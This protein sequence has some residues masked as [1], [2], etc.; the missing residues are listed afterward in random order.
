M[1][2]FDRRKMAYEAALRLYKDTQAAAPITSGSRTSAVDSHV[3]EFHLD[4]SPCRRVIIYLKSPGCKWAAQANG[5]CFMC[6]HWAGTE[7]GITIASELLIEQVRSELGKYDWSQYPVICVYNAGSF[8][9]DHEMPHIARVSILRTIADIQELKLVVIESR[10]EFINPR[11]AE[12]LASLLPQRLQVGVGLESVSDKVR[13]LC[14]NKGFEK[15]DFE[16]AVTTLRAHG[17]GTLAYVL[18][19]PPFLS[20]CE[21]I[22][23][24]IATITYAFEAG[25]E[26]VSLEPVSVQRHT[27]VERLA[28][29]N[30]YRVPWIWS[31]REVAKSTAHLGEVR[32]GGFEF[33][34][35]PDTVVHNCDRCND[36]AYAA[37]DDYNA[38]KSLERLNRLQCDCIGAWEADCARPIETLE[39][40]VVSDCLAVYSSLAHTT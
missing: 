38:T 3:R 1:E 39:Q 36:E 24:A 35:A 12:E 8:M 4:G 9:C 6:G 29:A 15:E 25:V 2:V 37:I 32:I 34:P 18:L 21:A 31:V 7:Q 30:V 5:G 26:A 33:R 40:R 27:L 16:E 22:E 17:I 11:A 23:D 10:P 28:N 13:R 19:K 20:E 14:V